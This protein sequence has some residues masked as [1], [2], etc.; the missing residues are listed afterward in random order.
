MT[1]IAQAE[2]PANLNGVQVFVHGEREAM[3]EVRK[4]LFDR[5]SLDR[6]QVSLSGYWAAGRT[7]DLFQAEKKLPVGKIL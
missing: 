7:E 4:E 3:K 5:R 1:A 2:W 6:S